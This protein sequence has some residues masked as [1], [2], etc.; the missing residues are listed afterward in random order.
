MTKLIWDAPGDR[1]YQTGLSNGVL[2]VDGLEGVPW[3]GLKAINE[4]PAGGIA[5]PRYF[6]G[7]KYFTSPKLEEFAA[8][9]E[10]YTYPDEFAQCMGM[11]S[12][13]PGIVLDQQARKEF[14]LVYKTLIGNDLQGNNLGYQIHLV[15]NATAGPN[16]KPHATIGESTVPIDFRWD[17]S[18]IGEEVVGY[19]PTAHLIITSTQ[20]YS[21]SLEALED[22][23]FG[24]DI[25]PATLPSAQ[26]VYDILT[27]ATPL[28]IHPDLLTGLAV[29]EVGLDDLNGTDIPGIYVAS[30]ETRL[31]ELGISGLYTLDE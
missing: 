19:L 6:D 8:T 9:I 15:Y 24:T 13:V 7:V 11:H 12:N 2:Y 28:E 16:E 10:A 30:P 21:K 29:L 14:G 3:N 1:V 4:R 26:E 20:I 23:L 5:I 31:T 27:K 22:I 18:C 17:I 25:T